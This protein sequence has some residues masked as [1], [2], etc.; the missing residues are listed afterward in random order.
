VPE[1][2][3]F[4]KLVYPLND[5][6]KAKA[7]LDRALSMTEQAWP[8]THQCWIDQLNLTDKLNQLTDEPTKLLEK[9]RLA[10]EPVSNND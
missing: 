5:L 6:L 9:H 8:Y 7:R 1:S 3:A 10:A 4:K 2:T